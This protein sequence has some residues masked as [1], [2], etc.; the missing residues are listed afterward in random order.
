[1]WA[2]KISICGAHMATRVFVGTL[3]PDT[4]TYSSPNINI[5]YCFFNSSGMKCTPLT[6]EVFARKSVQC[7]VSDDGFSP[8]MVRLDEGN[9]VDWSWS[10]CSVGH[11]V[12]E[13]VYNT[14]TGTL[15]QK[16][17]TR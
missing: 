13:L 15:I 5:M 2:T 16:D 11:T 10:S 6:I 9:R 3:A 7:Q 4:C 17:S 1:M 14:S 12:T 8:R